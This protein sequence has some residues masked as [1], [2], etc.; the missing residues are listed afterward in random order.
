MA[1]HVFCADATETV[2]NKEADPETLFAHPPQNARPMVYWFWMGRNLTKE[3]ITGDL[4][5]LKNAGFG[6]A[7]MC[8]LGDQCTPWPYEFENSLHPEMDPYTSIS[9]WDLVRHAASEAKRLGLEFGMHNRPGYETSGGPWI[10]PELSMLSTCY[11]VAE[12][13][14]PGEKNLI[15]NKPEVDPHS[16]SPW[17]VFNADE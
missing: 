8:N 3:G 4:E 1:L 5:A 14:G 11:S 6:G 9:W 17:P 7:T 16:D 12:V 2:S 13:S 15:L 10:T